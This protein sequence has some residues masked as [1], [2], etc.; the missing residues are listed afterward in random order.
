MLLLHDDSKPEDDLKFVSTGLKP[1]TKYPFSLDDVP[2][3][4]MAM[5][6]IDAN[7]CYEWP[8]C[9]VGSWIHGDYHTMQLQLHPLAQ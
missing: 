4:I 2:S 6:N 9:R 7:L 1:D 5:V 3:Y 8:F